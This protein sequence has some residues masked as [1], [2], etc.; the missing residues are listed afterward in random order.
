VFKKWVVT[1]VGLLI[2]V[3]L[4]PLCIELVTL[5]GFSFYNR[6]GLDSSLKEHLGDATFEDITVS[7]LLVAAYEFNSRTPRFY[8]KIF[9]DI[10]PGRYDVLLR[11]AV[12]ASSSAPTYFDPETHTNLFNITSSLVDGGIICNDPAL[13]AYMIAYNFYDRKNI[14]L[15]SL[16]TGHEPSMESSYSNPDSYSKF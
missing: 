9:R 10:D 3:L 5:I 1:V 2:G 16:G 6:A 12:G 8:S 15:I 4:A 14:K 13:Y 7:E 11:T